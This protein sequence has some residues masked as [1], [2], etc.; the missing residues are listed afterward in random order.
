MLAYDNHI[1]VVCSTSEREKLAG[2]GKTNWRFCQAPNCEY[3]H[4]KHG[5]VIKCAA[6]G[7]LYVIHPSCISD[8]FGVNLVTMWTGG[9]DSDPVRPSSPALL[10]P[11]ADLDARHVSVLLYCSQHEP[12]KQFDGDDVNNMMAALK[13]IP[14]DE[15]MP[16]EDTLPTKKKT[17]DKGSESESGS[18]SE[19]E[20]EVTRASSA[21]RHVRFSDPEC[22][23]R[24][25]FDDQAEEADEEEDEEED[26]DEPSYETAKKK[27]EERKKEKKA[28]KEKKEKKK[29]RSRD[30][31]EP[32]EYDNS[33]LS[34]DTTS[35]RDKI[36]SKGGSVIT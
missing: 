8:T 15:F 17:V 25:F 31:N 33:K 12:T 16:L 20:V 18:E 23:V 29:K 27:K 6:L 7:C 22:N 34:E 24:R 5:S 36:Y 9:G 11:R 2:E 35:F 3:P 26:E 30:N 32:N 10:L 14:I 21:K 13:M 1:H 28:K 4:M 19:K